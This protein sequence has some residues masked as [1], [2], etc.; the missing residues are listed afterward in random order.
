MKTLQRTYIYF[1]YLTLI[2]MLTACTPKN[3]TAATPEPVTPAKT[4][5][6]ATTSIAELEKLGFH[7]FPEPI[8]LPDFT[9]PALNGADLKQ[10]DFTGTVTILNFWA[11]WCPPCIKEMPSIQKLHEQMK[12]TSFRVVAISV[13]EKRKTVEDF[14]AK[15]KYTFPVYL[16]EQG[17]LGASF[18]SQGIPSTY[19]MDKSG[20][21]VAGTVGSREYDDPALI[22]ILKAMAQ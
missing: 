7:V 2:V 5:V 11:T 3:A 10:S 20:K 13:G 19:I 1:V 8:E 21:I 17:V 6:S 22:A 18:A 16:D 12:G 15:N 14:I 4:N 9:L